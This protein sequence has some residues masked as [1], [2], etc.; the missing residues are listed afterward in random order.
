MYMRG[1]ACWSNKQTLPCVWEVGLVDQMSKLYHVHERWGLLMKW[2]EFT[3]CMRGGFC[4]SNEQTLACAWEVG[5]VDQMSIIYH[6]YLTLQWVWEVGLV[7]WTDFAMYV[8]GGACWVNRLYHVYEMWGLSS[9][10]SL[11][12]EESYAIIEF[13]MYILMFY[14][15]VF[16][17]SNV[18]CKI[19]IKNYQTKLCVW[20][21]VFVGWTDFT[22]C[23]RGQ[24]CWVNRLYHVHER[25]G[26][27]I[28]WAD[29]IMCM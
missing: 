10:Q 11:N 27:L 29:F 22:M 7:G 25:S 14:L 9:E 8:R 23:M 18:Q 26:L 12:K 28:K 6:V 15:Y 5:F 24:A 4:W 3:M 21:M 2:A 19:W 1:R 20:E 13:F 16:L 17:I